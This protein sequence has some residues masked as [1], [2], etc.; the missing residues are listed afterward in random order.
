[1]STKN[2]ARTVIEGGRTSNYKSDVDTAY[3]E[4]RAA[5][6]EFLRRAT[7][8]PEAAEALVTPKRRPVRPQFADKLNPAHQFLDANCGRPWNKVKSELFKKF[9]T[10]TTPGRHVMFDHILNDVDENATW[11]ETRYSRY[12]RWFVD[13]SG[14]LQRKKTT[15]SRFK[16]REIPERSPISKEKVALWLG[17]RKVGRCGERLVWFHPT[18]DANHVKVLWGKREYR[19]YQGQ[20]VVCSEY[21][22][23]YVV[24]HQDGSVMLRSLLMPGMPRFWFQQ[25]HSEQEDTTPYRQGKLLTK[26]EEEYL[27]RLPTWTRKEIL[28]HAPQHPDYKEPLFA[29]KKG[30]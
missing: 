2:L 26:D 4:E 27:L 28:E 11:S 8:D 30:A 1:M 23:K 16:K 15:T 12:Y 21:G 7:V 9:D 25:T 10:R 19:S 6:R 17:N 5:S 14:L 13:K 18:R 20:A 24:L 3:R 29:L 22:L